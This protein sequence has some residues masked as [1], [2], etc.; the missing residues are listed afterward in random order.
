MLGGA[1]EV[2]MLGDGDEVTKLAQGGQRPHRSA[3]SLSRKF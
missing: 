2:A 3:R 1:P